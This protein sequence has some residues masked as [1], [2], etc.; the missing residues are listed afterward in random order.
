MNS[1]LIIQNMAKIL[2]DE[3][4]EKAQNG[5]YS[6]SYDDI[7]K[8]FE[9]GD[10]SEDEVN[11]IAEEMDN[12]DEV[13]EVETTITNFEIHLAETPYQQNKARLYKNSEKE[14]AKLLADFKDGC[15]SVQMGYQ[16][17]SFFEIAVKQQIKDYIA[18][19]LD[20]GY[21][22]EV[23]LLAEQDEPL[24]FIFSRSNNLIGEFVDDEI[25]NTIE[26]LPN[27]TGGENEI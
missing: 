14:W 25:S 17:P 21:D 13:W 24:E 8:R 12:Y 4:W 1:E 3:A 15:K 27:L 7:V 10:L 20:E 16:M 2:V 18:D 5:T 23:A 6:V 11:K 22:K 26:I 9:L 19:F